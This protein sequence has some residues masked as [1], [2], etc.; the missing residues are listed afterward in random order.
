MVHSPCRTYRALTLGSEI[1]GPKG[2]PLF[3]AIY[4][5]SVARFT[6]HRSSLTASNIADLNCA[7]RRS[8]FLRFRGLTMRPAKAGLHHTWRI[9]VV[10]LAE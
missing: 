1:T 10:Y 4:L 2:I 7:G 9:T 5:A 3:G 6:S 8:R